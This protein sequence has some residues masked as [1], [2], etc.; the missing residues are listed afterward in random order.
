VRRFRFILPVLAALGL[1]GCG[2]QVRLVD[3]QVA[4]GYTG[5][6]RRVFVVDVTHP[7]YGSFI[8]ADFRAGMRDG[9]ARCGIAVADFKTDAWE[10][11]SRRRG[12]AQITAFDPDL[13]V[14]IAMVRS[15]STDAYQVSARER[16]GRMVWGTTIETYGRSGADMA[17]KV[18]ERMA[19]DRILPACANPLPAAGPV[20]ARPGTLPGRTP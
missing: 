7:L 5:N 12:S 13:L 2:P 9:L 19:A 18:I 17:A 6:P 4:T 8:S 20:A 11:D 14:R 15:G 1:A 3:T 10:L 16:S